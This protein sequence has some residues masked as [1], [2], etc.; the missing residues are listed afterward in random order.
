MDSHF[1]MVKDGYAPDV[2]TTPVPV[3]VHGET[4]FHI[5]HDEHNTVNITI[6]PGVYRFTLLPRGLRPPA[7]WPEWPEP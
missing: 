2:E 5:L 1:V 3:A 6:H 7:E 4:T